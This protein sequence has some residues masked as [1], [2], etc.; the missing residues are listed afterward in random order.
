MMH[1][2]PGV[3][4]GAI[5]TVV[6]SAFSIL[7][8]TLYAASLGPPQVRSSLGERLDVL[9]PVR[10]ADGELVSSSCFSIQESGSEEITQIYA[11]TLTY[12]SAG[13]SMLRV[14][15]NFPIQEP[16]VQ[17]TLR[18]QCDGGSGA[19]SRTYTLLV[20][21]KP[22]PASVPAEN[23]QPLQGSGRGANASLA[24]A[25]PKLENGK[26][27]AQSG[28]SLQ[29]VIRFHYPND[30]E[31]RRKMLFWIRTHNTGLPR[32]RFSPLP[33]GKTLNLPTD[34]QARAVK[35]APLP[36]ATGMPPV[37][38]NA[39]VAGQKKASP[40]R[41]ELSSVSP[42]AVPVTSSN[43][44]EAELKAHEKALLLQADDQVARLLELKAQ[45]SRLERTLEQLHQSAS[46]FP[47]S[48]P[49]KASEKS[50]PTPAVVPVEAKV[51]NSR[52]GFLWTGGIGLVATLVAG[53]FLLRRKG[54]EDADEAFANLAPIPAK[55]AQPSLAS[56]GNSADSTP[57]AVSK[58]TP[59]P[60]LTESV[61][62]VQPSSLT[63]EIELL[64]A[65]GQVEA[66]ASL[67]EE[68]I[69]TDPHRALYRF[70]QLEIHFAQKN[71]MQFR[72][73]AEAF[74]RQFPQSNLWLR[75]C[76]MGRQFEA[77]DPLYVPEGPIETGP[78]DLSGDFSR[79]MME[80]LLMQSDVAAKSREVAPAFSGDA[81]PL[82][83][84]HPAA[85][86]L[87]NVRLDIPALS[88]APAG[89]GMT[90]DERVA[91][92]ERVAA[93]I[94]SG[95]Q[96]AARML[97]EKLSQEDSLETLVQVAETLHQLDEGSDKPV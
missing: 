67:L 65:H 36:L 85:N 53:V 88:N 83:S 73:K 22:E 58:S 45:V 1:T 75:I 27:I 23:A 87:A 9:V 7:P 24:T 54:R 93:Y 43:P 94:K 55:V 69:S 96:A 11:G 92:F 2:H 15:S 35:L 57:T 20:D 71:A 74:H 63:E 82:T 5:T 72:I 61:D 34:E 90:E 95:N 8:T 33:V 16:M 10:L 81:S 42:S 77:D 30:R 89:K 66:A 46:A 70:W 31:M 44:T 39:N 76:E 12:P 91:A 37:T 64:M 38:A 19:S 18:V 50:V 51:E 60:S 26:W 32:N 78:E 41:L 56:R 3:R 79:E 59:S 14:Q 28:E 62:V 80:D 40:S 68:A 97:L 86:E 4:R 6:L 49:E 47:A 17:I 84:P 52:W 29:R 48:E 25:A 13:K 21:P